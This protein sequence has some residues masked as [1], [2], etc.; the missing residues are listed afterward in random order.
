M[1]QETLMNS[2]EM[3]KDA[4]KILNVEPGMQD[5]LIERASSLASEMAI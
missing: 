1:K 5:I 2:M 4:I 3:L